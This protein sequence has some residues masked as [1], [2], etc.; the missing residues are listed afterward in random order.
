M[1]STT[2]NPAAQRDGLRAALRGGAAGMAAAL[3][4]CALLGLSPFAAADREALALAGVSIALPLGVIVA[5]PARAARQASNVALAALSAGGTLAL[6]MAFGDVALLLRLAVWCAA[7]A[8]LGAALAALSRNQWPGLAA[9]GLWLFLC[10]L[11]FFCGRMGPLT[12]RMEDWALQGCPWLGFAQ[13]ALDTDPLRRPVLY[14]GKWSPLSDS[15]AGEFLTAGTLWVAAALAYAAL[16]AR[17]GLPRTE[18]R[19]EPQP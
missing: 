17:A 19:P 6:G 4:V 2:N 3:L 12:S 18:P 5:W 7:A 13:D 8:L 10:G 14:L 1:N 11:P 9:A 15:P 16:L